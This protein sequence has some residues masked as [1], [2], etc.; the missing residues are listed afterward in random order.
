MKFLK[1]VSLV[2]LVAACFVFAPNYVHGKNNNKNNKHKYE[3]N[4]N[5]DYN[6]QNKDDD[7]QGHSYKYRGKYKNF[8][9][10]NHHNRYYYRGKYYNFKDYYRYYSR[11]NNVFTYEGSYGKH[12]NIFIFSDRYGNEF[13]LYLKPVSINPKRFKGRPLRPGYAYNIRVH[14]ER[15]YP[16]K[17]ELNV[18][19][20][21]SFGWGNLTL[22]NDKYYD[23]YSAPQLVNINGRVYIK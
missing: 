15:M 7:N 21:L 11:E 23:M 4:N 10:N 5:N 16:S 13:D 18:G 22:T 2:T 12:G 9:N 1:Y 3:N 20:N 8:S 6:K 17:N 14:P 19:L